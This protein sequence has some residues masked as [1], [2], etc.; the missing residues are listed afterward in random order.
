MP[1]QIYLSAGKVE[2]SGLGIDTQAEKQSV[3]FAIN[4]LKKAIE[5]RL[6]FR[7]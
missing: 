2:N 6:K 1:F 4:R 7:N 5:C 3:D